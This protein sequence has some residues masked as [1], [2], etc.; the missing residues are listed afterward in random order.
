MRRRLAIRHGNDTV[1]KSSGCADSGGIQNGAST[2][3]KVTRMSVCSQLHWP[4]IKMAAILIAVG[5]ADALVVMFVS[6]P[7][8]WAVLIPALV[9][10]LT[11]V[12]VIIP[13]LNNPK[14]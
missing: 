6:R 10:L 4:L 9:P 7:L 3:P 11:A 12:F 2:L 5:L 14:S 8:P 1:G 13:I